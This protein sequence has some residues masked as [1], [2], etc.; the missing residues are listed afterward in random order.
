MKCGEARPSGAIEPL[1]REEDAE[2]GLAV[3]DERLCV[4][5]VGAKANWSEPQK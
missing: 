2:M 5:Y 4:T 3:V 1:T